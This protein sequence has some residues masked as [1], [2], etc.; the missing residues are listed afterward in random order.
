M[1]VTAEM[2]ARFL[3]GQT[4]ERTR[5][6]DNET[7]IFSIF[8]REYREK[9][10]YTS[11]HEKRRGGDKN[12]QMAQCLPPE[13]RQVPDVGATSVWHQSH[14]HQQQHGDRDTQAGAA[15]DHTRDYRPSHQSPH[16]QRQDPVNLPHSPVASPLKENRLR[17]LNRCIPVDPHLTSA[18]TSHGKE[19]CQS[20]ERQNP[21]LRTDFPHSV[22]Q[23]YRQQSENIKKQQET[24]RH[25][26]W[27]KNRYSKM[28]IHEELVKTSSGLV[29]FLKV[30]SDVIMKNVWKTART[31]TRE[32]SESPEVG[33]SLENSP[34]SPCT[35]STT[36]LASPDHPGDRGVPVSPSHN[37]LP[38]ELLENV[39]KLHN[40]ED[41][42]SEHI[43]N[44]MRE[45]LDTCRTSVFNSSYRH[46]TPLK[47]KLQENNIDICVTS[48]S[49]SSSYQ[50]YTLLKHKMQELDS[51]DV[52]HKRA[53]ITGS[54]QT[55]PSKTQQLKT[56]ANESNGHFQAVTPELVDYEEVPS[57]K[58]GGKN[59]ST[60]EIPSRKIDKNCPNEISS[61]KIDKNCSN[62]D[63]CSRKTGDKNCSDID[64]NGPQQERFI[65]KEAMIPLQT[66]SVI[67]PA[68]TDSDTSKGDSHAVKCKILPQA[69]HVDKKIKFSP[70][71]QRIDEGI[72]ACPLPTPEVPDVGDRRN[73]NSAL[74][75]ET[76][77]IP[78]DSESVKYAQESTGREYP[79]MDSE[80]EEH[81]EKRPRKTSDEKHCCET[82]GEKH[83]G[84]PGERH[85]RGTSGEGY[86]R[87]TLGKKHFR[88]SAGV[89]HSQESVEGAKHSQESAESEKDHRK[90]S[91]HSQ[92]LSN[93]KKDYTESPQHSQES[94]ETGKD[95]R[96][97][98]PPR[99]SITEDNKRNL[100]C[101]H[102]MRGC[103][104]Q[105]GCTSLHRFPKD[106]NVLCK[107][108]LKGMCRRGSSRCWYKHAYT[109][110][111][112][113]GVNSCRGDE[114]TIDSI[115][116][117]IRNSK[118]PIY[119]CSSSIDNSFD[120][121]ES[122]YFSSSPTKVSKSKSKSTLQTEVSTVTEQNKLS[123]SKSTLQTEVSTVTEQNKLSPS[124][125]TLQTEVSTVTE[126]NKLSPS[127]ST[128]QTEVSTVTEQNKLSPSKSTL[129]TE[130]S[131]VTEQNKL[132][133]SKSTL[134]T[135]VSTVTEQNKLSPSKSTLQTEVSTVTEQNKLS[136]S[137]STLQTEVSTVTEQ[138]KLS[139]SKS[140]LQTE[141]STV[142]EQ[143]KLSPSKSTLQTEVSTVT[144][145]NKLS[146][147]KSTLQTEVS[148]VTEQNKL[149]PS[150]STLQTEV[151]TVTE[152]NKLSPSKSTL[153][154]EVSTVTEQNK[155]S[156]SKSTLQTE[157]STV[158]EQNKLSPS[159]S[160]LQTEVSTVT[161]QNKLSPSKSTLQTEVSTV[162]EQNKLSPSKSTL[163]TE[164]STVT[165]QN[166][167]SP[168]KSTLQTEVSTVTE[169]NKLSP[170]KSTLQTEVSTVTEQN[171]LSP[172]KS[173]LQTEVSTVTEQNKLSPSK[174]TLQ[175]EVSTV[176]EQNKLSLSKSTLQTEVKGTQQTISTDATVQPT[177]AHLSAE[178]VKLEDE[179]TCKADYKESLNFWNSV[180]EIQRRNRLG[181]SSSSN[182][183]TK[184]LS[185]SSKSSPTPYRHVDHG[186]ANTQSNS[187]S[188]K[189]SLDDST[190][191]SIRDSLI[192]QG[193]AFQE[194]HHK[195]LVKKHRTKAD[196]NS[197]HRRTRKRDEVNQKSKSR[198][199]HKSRS[200]LFYTTLEKSEGDSRGDDKCQIK[201]SK[202]CKTELDLPDA[203]SE[204]S[205]RTDVRDSDTSSKKSKRI[206]PQD[207][208]T[209]S[210]KSKR[211]DTQDS[212]TSSKKS[213][214]T[215]P[216][217]SDTSSK[218]S[219]RT[220]LRDSD[221]SSKSKRTDSQN[222]D[223]SSK[224]SKRT[225]SQDSGTS[226]KK[227]KRTDP[228]DS[229]TSSKS[230][231][232]DPQDS[233][234]S[235]KPKR[236]DPQDSG[237]SSAPSLLPPLEIIKTESGSKMCKALDSPKNDSKSNKTMQNC[238]L[239]Q[240]TCLEKPTVQLHSNIP[241][242]CNKTV[243]TMEKPT[244]Q[245][246]PD[247]LNQCNKT[248]LTM[249]KPTVQLHP[250]IPNQCNKTVLTMDKPT[251][252]LH[253]DIPNQCNKTVLT[254]DKPT[255]QL[256]SD[257]PNQC[258]KTVLTMDKPTVHPE[259]SINHEKCLN[260]NVAESISEESNSVIP[261]A[262]S[263]N[264]A[265]EVSNNEPANVILS[266]RQGTG[267]KREW[268]LE[269]YTR[270]FL[271]EY[272]RDPYECLC[273]CL[274]KFELEPWE[275][276]T[277]SRSHNWEI[278]LRRFMVLVGGTCGPAMD[279]PKEFILHSMLEE[280]NLSIFQLKAW[281]EK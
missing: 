39:L 247:I 71:E 53:D 182:H 82:S 194:K 92:E 30:N 109:A 105:R 281:M 228:Q 240:E 195:K 115:I 45:D 262:L 192:Q 57:Q 114:A 64:T 162:T 98:S 186:E 67:G 150:K 127:K 163:Q 216:Q 26:N 170:S 191:K 199:K 196:K 21:T 32:M 173:T 266:L 200:F 175:T 214:R 9:A 72:S 188:T 136:P 142:T 226:S 147:S 40:P 219:E 77:C 134:Q 90:S 249:E 230:K 185:G 168:S 65:I 18:S 231:R 166:K 210:K 59:C 106:D 62:N 159:K 13:R 244:V 120:H 33:T 256:H 8:G 79:Q 201:L 132:S 107:D 17:Y 154:T 73:P 74:V 84:T 28:E 129:Q 46:Y 248:V 141:V 76:N 205:E 190:D 223:T 179:E 254:M 2:T 31:P 174:S 42:S 50:H 83:Q 245:L 5:E 58:S 37:L 41:K 156:P 119:E 258:N 88:E 235:S 99:D 161:E 176:T 16:A 225:D 209:S 278:N 24:Y 124:K 121:F 232:T 22:S 280:P 52:G 108:F 236:T 7:I 246:H 274:R 4:D 239:R 60:N 158:T 126:Q 160:T 151:S 51:K 224:K 6:S 146:P 171:K 55:T 275:D 243:L 95:H 253:P 251:V 94:S 259:T 89:K 12:S 48:A 272:E 264:N 222:S 184:M 86:S 148:T 180:K 44:K 38:K 128:L 20:L 183:S 172:S 122:L 149:S 23:T 164:V 279:V 220:D 35:K 265:S 152:Q 139:P 255:V 81:I 85:S 63:V 69:S 11:S 229:G 100:R 3:L 268:I 101:Q 203:S 267:Q 238:P 193:G 104:Y 27:D 140:T 165:E 78:R 212:D 215:D 14:C 233:G 227:P 204:E 68:T 123:P 125:S 36:E 157:V 273:E 270:E 54:Y 143:N 75:V 97:S 118:V 49:N 181:E 112:R 138:N 169:Q 263:D 276:A 117:A 80:K 47:Y 189:R 197:K 56:P 257:I 187:E 96:I 111:K 202:M 252:Q 15:S 34:E 103:C 133:P 61:Q 217:D 137:K 131:T 144:E 178:I 87:E 66:Q 269:H 29:A 110:A 241:N 261:V 10:P 208:D 113:D 155:L 271:E 211:T 102:Y 207:S 242:Q 206:D 116:L 43:Q 221:A 167:L 250:D 177:V 130:V 145:Q 237:T 19:R 135:E 198:K 213:K 218:K 153:Q 277:L 25:R 70:A 260:T 93:R 1:V 91:Q 234:T